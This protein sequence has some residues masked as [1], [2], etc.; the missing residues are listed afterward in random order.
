MFVEAVVCTLTFILALFTLNV[1]RVI[2]S[3]YFLATKRTVYFRV[4]ITL[5]N[6]IYEIYQGDVTVCQKFL[7]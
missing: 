7:D 3:L 5:H 2:V 6:V 4:L 1:L